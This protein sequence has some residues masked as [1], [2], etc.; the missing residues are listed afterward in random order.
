M[1]LKIGILSI[2]LATILTAVYSS[3]ALYSSSVFATENSPSVDCR[4]TKDK[5]TSFCTVEGD[6]TW[7]CDKQK[8]GTWKCGEIPRESGPNLPTD[9][10]KALNL[11]TNAV[12][13]SNTSPQKDFTSKKDELLKNDNQFQKVNPDEG[14]NSSST[15]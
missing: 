15:G 13:V 6:G 4:Y 5:K 3:S 14:S 2:T 9:L 7:R 1:T 10:K 8:N 12:N 11:A